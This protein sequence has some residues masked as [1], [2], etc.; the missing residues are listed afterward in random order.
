MDQR[1]S[2]QPPAKVKGRTA[3]CSLALTM[4]PPA[5]SWPRPRIAVGTDTAQSLTWGVEIAVSGAYGANTMTP[6]QEAR[7]ASRALARRLTSLA[8]K[9]ERQGRW[10]DANDLVTAAL[11]LRELADAPSPLDGQRSLF[12]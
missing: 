1:L 5:P 8:T 9:L 7:R 10:S 3:R 11:V 2:L 12:A 4:F 6:D